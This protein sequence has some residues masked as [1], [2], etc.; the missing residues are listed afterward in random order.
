MT[1]Y[2]L[3]DWD[4]NI[5]ISIEK[6]CEEKLVDYAGLTHCLAVVKAENDYLRYCGDSFENDVAGASNA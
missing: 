6:E 4:G 5:F 1:D 3:K 2:I